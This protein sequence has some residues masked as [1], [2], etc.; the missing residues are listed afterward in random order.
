MPKEV[1]V[2]KA[3]RALSISVF[4]IAVGFGL[5]TAQDIPS[6]YQQVLKNV[7]KSGDYKSNV[8]KS[9][10]HATTFTSPSTISRC[11]RLSALADGSL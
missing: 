3:I 1:L 9:T 8:L 5:G 7:G 6:D 4:I 10:F 2:N 11:P